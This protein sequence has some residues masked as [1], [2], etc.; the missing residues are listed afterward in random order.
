MKRDLNR[1]VRLFQ[2][3]RV[4]QTQPE[5]FYGALADDSVA[6]VSEHIDLRGKTVL[7]VGAGPREFAEAF[8]QAGARYIPLDRDPEVESVR[9]G[10]VVGDALAL[11]LA[12]G[13][14]DVVFSSNLAEHVPNPTA[15]ADEMVRVLRP[16][17]VLFLSYTN[18]LSPWGGHETSPWHWLGGEF[19]VRRYERKHGHAPKNRV[20]STLY[21]ISV[22][23]GLRWARHQPDLDVIALR[24]RYYPDVARVILRVPVLRE[25]VTWN[26]LVLGRKR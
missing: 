2:A 4:E 21:R 24:P 5:V 8:R 6:I 25:F 3:F 20:D 15:A 14:V 19:A 11:P 22:E 10:G 13:S 12:S 1:S 17:G 18:W 23:T 7:D 16:G 9:D 26:L